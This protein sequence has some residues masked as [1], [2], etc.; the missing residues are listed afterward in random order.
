LSRAAAAEA[1]AEEGLLVGIDGA[2]ITLTQLT[3]ALRALDRSA[4]DVISVDVVSEN[5]FP[6]SHSGVLRLALADGS[7]PRALFLKK[8][9]PGFVGRPWPDRRRTLAYARTEARFYREFASEPP[10]AIAL[11]VGSGVARLPRLAA[12]DD[13]LGA[14]LGAAPV[15]APAGD[16]PSAARLRAGGALLLLE[17]AEGFVQAS[18]LGEADAR[19]ALRAVAGLH[20]AGWEAAPLLRRASERLQRH[21]SVYA[22]EIRSPSELAKLR[23]NWDAFVARFGAEAPALRDLELGARLERWTCW[24][25]AQV[26]VCLCVHAERRLQM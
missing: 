11:S 4:P 23:P 15:H 24:A 25:S 12:S 22:L 8:V 26:G 3:Q 17:C 10:L 18:P 19:A 6:G 14:L 9:T 2:P 13:R 20:A 1:A 5:R 7:A 16:E 21:G